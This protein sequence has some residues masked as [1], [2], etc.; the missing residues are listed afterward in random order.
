MN[1]ND[2]SYDSVLLFNDRQLK[3]IHYALALLSLMCFDF[4]NYHKNSDKCLI[5]VP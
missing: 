5:P 2:S 1:E 4:I 3:N